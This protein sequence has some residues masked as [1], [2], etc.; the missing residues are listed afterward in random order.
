M[1][2]FSEISSSGL[3]QTKEEEEE[4]VKFQAFI[5]LLAIFVGKTQMMSLGL[6]L[7]I[8]QTDCAA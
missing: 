6:A 2:Q 3:N 5:S 8:R 4:E 7:S 1:I